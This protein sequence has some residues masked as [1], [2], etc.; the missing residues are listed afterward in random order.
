MLAA[1]KGSGSIK[2]YTPTMPRRNRVHIARMP[3]D[4]VQRSFYPGKRMIKLNLAPYF[5]F[6]LMLKLNLTPYFSY[7]LMRPDG[8]PYGPMKEGHVSIGPNLSPE[9]VKQASRP[10]RSLSDLD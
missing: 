2:V 9:V 8:R 4:I 10:I 6:S 1:I 7:L 5:L 3:L